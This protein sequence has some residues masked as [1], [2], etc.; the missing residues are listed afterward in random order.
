M[1]LTLLLILVNVAVFVYGYQ[2]LGTFI[3][4][5]GFSAQAFSEGRYWTLLTA[6][7]IHGSILH[8]AGNMV[9]LLF[10]GEVV[11]GYVSKLSYLLVYFLS[12]IA[13]NLGVLLLSLVGI[14]PVAVGASA[15][16]SGLIGY[17]A[18][19]YSGKWVLSPIRFIPVPMPFMVAGALYLVMNS[20]GLFVLNLSLASG[21]HLIGGVVGALFALRD[22]EHKLRKLIVFSAAVVLIS[23]VPYGIKY[24]L[25]ML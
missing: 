20:V 3:Q 21:G 2:N 10:M 7:F 1:R 18:F 25:G 14:N 23:L 19:K 5:Y 13:A 12:G 22:E 8:L 4:E 11:E 17:G 16:I 24:L 15:A 6:L 9:V